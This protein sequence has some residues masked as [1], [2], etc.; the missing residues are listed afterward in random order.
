MWYHRPRQQKLFPSLPTWPFVSLILLFL[1]SRRCIDVKQLTEEISSSVVCCIHWC[2]GI[3]V[4]RC[5]M[6]SMFLVNFEHLFYW[7]VFE[8]WKRTS[9]RY[10]ITLWVTYSRITCTRRFFVII[11][12]VIGSI[13]FTI[14]SYRSLS[15][16][17]VLQSFS[18]SKRTNLLKWYHFSIH[19]FAGVT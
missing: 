8:S 10:T 9:N 13:Q 3:K 2:F 18:V 19:N 16:T 12:T 17:N 7:L 6:Y 4:Q 5:F 14:Y 11:H 15:I 1:S